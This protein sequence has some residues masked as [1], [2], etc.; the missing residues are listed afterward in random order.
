MF[1][2]LFSTVSFPLSVYGIGYVMFGKTNRSLDLLKKTYT[3]PSAVFL[4]AASIK[5]YLN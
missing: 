4:F 1:A 5:C 2:G 3:I